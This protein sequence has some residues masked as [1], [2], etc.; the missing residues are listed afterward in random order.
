[1]LP[2]VILNILD[3][4]ELEGV[5]AHELGH[6]R[7]RDILTSSI[8]APLAGA[9]TVLARMG[10][11]GAMFGG[12]GGDDRDRRGGGLGALLMVIL[13][14]LAAL[15]IQLWGSRARGNEAE[16]TGAH[17]TCNPFAPARGLP[18]CVR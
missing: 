11:W 17:L 4:D 16:S 7:N 2:Q 6:W 14:P 10:A 5:R 8:A 9:V 13:A 15:L 3:N 12:Y 1:P 18:K